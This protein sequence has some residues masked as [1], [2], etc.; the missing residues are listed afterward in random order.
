MM[1][2][3]CREKCGFGKQGNQIELYN[4]CIHPSSSEIFVATS[5]E[6]SPSSTTFRS[7]PR[8]ADAS[9]PQ[10]QLGSRRQRTEPSK[11]TRRCSLGFSYEYG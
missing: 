1:K 7:T 6:F 4:K 2:D 3:V 11:S 8:S 10:R 9:E 5:L